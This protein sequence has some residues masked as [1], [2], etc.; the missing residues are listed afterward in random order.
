MKIQL[1]CAV[2]TL[3]MTGAFAQTK[4]TAF[5]PFDFEAGG[6]AFPGGTYEIQ[7]MGSMPIVKFT[8]I[9]MKKS[10][11]ISAPVPAG[12]VKGSVPKLVFRATGDLHSLTEIWL[13]DVPGMKTFGSS[14]A[15]GEEASIKIGSR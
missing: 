7:K 3:G 2:V 6:A 10:K 14:K 13:Q 4:H 15:R 5:I 11:A 9:E 1:L 12:S 8:N